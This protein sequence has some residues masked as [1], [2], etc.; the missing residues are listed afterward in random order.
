M[1]ELDK[2]KPYFHVHGDASGAAY[3]QGGKMFDGN[4]QQVGLI[5]A[6]DDVADDVAEGKGKG[7]KAK[8]KAVPADA[9]ADDSPDN[10]ADAAGATTAVDAQLAA[11]G[12]E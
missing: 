1:A 3:E 7:K 12:A 9:P 4:G 11:Q 6:D 10:A 5:P 8:A 2:S